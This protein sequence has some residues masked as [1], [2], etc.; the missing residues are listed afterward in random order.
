[1]ASQ[2]LKLP[3]LDNPKENVQ[4]TETLVGKTT[5]MAGGIGGDGDSISTKET[6]TAFGAILIAAVIYY[7]LKNSVSR[8]LVAKYNKSPRSADTASWALFTIM[9]FSTIAVVL[10]ILDYSKFLTLLYL[11]PLGIVFIITVA[12]LIMALNSDR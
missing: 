2:D 12:I 1:M 4:K 3:D 7:F 11:I 6:V 9:L 8:M 10:A 5:D